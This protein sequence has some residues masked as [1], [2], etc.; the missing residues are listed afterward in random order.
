M[1]PRTKLATHGRNWCPEKSR[2]RLK[3]PF[4]P[5]QKADLLYCVAPMVCLLLHFEVGQSDLAF[6]LLCRKYGATAAW[7]PMY[8]RWHRLYSS[9]RLLLDPTQYQI[10]T[11]TN[12]F[13]VV[14]QLAGDNADILTR[15]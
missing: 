4:P 10:Q 11:C 15:A 8:E 7:T 2:R 14:F 9:D 12:D 5:M 3:S 6:R 1:N 13:P